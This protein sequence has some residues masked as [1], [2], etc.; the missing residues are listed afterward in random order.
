MQRSSP[1]GCLHPLD[2]RIARRMTMAFQ[3]TGT[4]A[5]GRLPLL[6]AILFVS[7]LCVAMPL[8]IVPVFATER[9]GL[10]NAWAG[11]AVG[12]AFL[13]TILT[14]GYAGTFSDRLGAKAAL[15]RGL[16]FY[17]AGALTTWLAGLLFH[18]PLTAFCVLLAGRLL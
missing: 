1:I 14:R 9:L 13:S 4:P 11:L 3:V 10:G 16:V 12:I 7:Y 18:T 5:W 17:L 6:I 8:P 2:A 15:V